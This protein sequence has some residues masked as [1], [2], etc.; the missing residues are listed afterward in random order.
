MTKKIFSITGEYIELI[1]LLKVAHVCY[2]GG[3]AKQIVEEGLVQL[4]GVSESRK[5]AKIRKGDVVYILKKNI[6][7][8]VDITE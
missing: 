2:S 8:T 4:N 6:E 3:E 1:K 7:I 5:R